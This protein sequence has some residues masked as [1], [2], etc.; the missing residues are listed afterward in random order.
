MKTWRERIAEAR[1]RGKFTTE[2]RA[3]AGGWEH[4]AVGECTQRFGLTGVDRL[5]LEAM[6]WPG[7]FSAGTM[8]YLRVIANHAS[9]AEHILDAIEDRALEL[10]RAPEASGRSDSAAAE[11]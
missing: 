4:C 1:A 10:K 2:D 7:L 11:S 3:L 5:S 6:P 8:F 9:E